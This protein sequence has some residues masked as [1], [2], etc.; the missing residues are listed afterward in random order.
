MSS[1]AARPRVQWRDVDGILLLDKPLALSS[2]QALQQARRLFRARKAGH[3]GSLDPLASGLLPLCFGEA[4]KVSGFL[5]DADKHYVARLVLGARTTTGDAEGEVVARAPIPPLDAAAVAR[6]L[7]GFVGRQRQVPP[8]YS[9]LKRDGRPLYELARAGIEVE[10][11][12]REVEILRL[13]LLALGED[14]LEFEVECSKGTY[15]RTL[16]E[17]I[18]RA[19]GT[20]G[21]LVALRRTAIGAL[22]GYRAWTLEELSALA[23]RGESEL[24]AALLPIDAGLDWP[25]ETLDDVRVSDVLHGRA[26]PVGIPDAAHARLRDAAG[27]LVALAAVQS[28]RAAPFR[29]IAPAR[30][31]TIEPEPQ[32]KGASSSAPEGERSS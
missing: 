1:A 27:R 17:D 20:E 25:A 18:A 19:L 14:S 32:R 2:N 10:H 28:G 4:T 23:A 5:L 11:D 15:V 26:V 16:G 21:H 12:A 22:D 29:V 3:T 30:S 31:L 8:M 6:A 9:A 24:D 13:D 7:A